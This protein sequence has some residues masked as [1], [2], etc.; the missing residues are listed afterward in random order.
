MASILVA[1]VGNMFLGDDGFGV[2]VARRLTTCSMPDGVR[3]VDFG[4]RSYDLAYAMMEE[5]D[6]VLLVDAVPRGGQAG[7]VYLIEP[8]LAEI[9]S[10]LETSAV[11]GHTMN[12][13]AVFRLVKALGGELPRV[14]IV[15]CEPAPAEDDTGMEDTMGLSLPVQAGVEEA[16]RLIEQRCA[17]E[18]KPAA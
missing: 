13:A 12:P 6:L 9:D 7:T 17:D 14:L 3:V 15:G 16:L 11:D 4:I 18:I 1:C 5:W 2:E 10:A 8:D